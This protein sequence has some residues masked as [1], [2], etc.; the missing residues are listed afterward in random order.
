[1]ISG[2]P[3]S[4]QRLVLPS[5]SA[6]KQAKLRP[7]LTDSA[8][9]L[10]LRIRRAKSREISVLEFDLILT[11]IFFLLSTSEFFLSSL[12]V[13]DKLYIKNISFEFEIYSGYLCSNNKGTL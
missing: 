1:M 10:C 2:K 6:N 8:D 4:S 7:T 3:M 13:A 9:R 12:T 11:S 5:Y